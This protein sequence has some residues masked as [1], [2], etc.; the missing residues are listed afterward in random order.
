MAARSG[1]HI[2]QASRPV[3]TGGRDGAAVGTEHHRVDQSGVTGQRL[4]DLAPAGHVPHS[5]RPV[6]GDDG[7]SLA[8]GTEHQRAGQARVA[9]KAHQLNLEIPA[10]YFWATVGLAWGVV[11]LAAVGAAVCATPDPLAD[12]GLHGV[13]SSRATG[14]RAGRGSVPPLR[15]APATPCATPFARPSRIRGCPG[16]PARG[17]TG[18]PSRTA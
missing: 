8:L 16:R 13:T 4:A 17:R 5:H 15:S 7:Q 1:V 9:A 18:R 2:P 6:V 11:A 3:D 14:G 12:A 10:S